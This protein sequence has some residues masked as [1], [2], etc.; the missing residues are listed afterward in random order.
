MVPKILD[1]TA[2]NQ[3]DV[4]SGCGINLDPVSICTSLY[5]QSVDGR[6]VLSAARHSN[7]NVPPSAL[8][9]MLDG[10]PLRADLTWPPHP[11]GSGDIWPP[12]SVCDAGE[13]PLRYPAAYALSDFLT[14]GRKPWASNSARIRPRH[15]PSPA[16]ALAAVY[17]AIVRP[18]TLRGL[19]QK[20]IVVI[21]NNL[22]SV[23]QQELLDE[24]ANAG[25]HARLLW[26]PVAA[27]LGLEV[28]RQKGR[29]GN[30]PFKS[31][32]SVGVLHLGLDEWE[33]TPMEYASY[34]GM[35]HLVPA[36][37][38]PDR[39]MTLSSWGHQVMHRVAESLAKSSQAPNVWLYVWRLLWT[40]PWQELVLKRL[41]G[42]ADRDA[43][44]ASGLGESFMHESEAL[45]KD[46][47]LQ[48]D[49]HRLFT[50]VGTRLPRWCGQAGVMGW[51][52]LVKGI[53]TKLGIKSIVVSGPLASIR[54]DDGVRLGEDLTSLL[55]GSHASPFAL[56]AYAPETLLGLGAGYCAM[57]YAN[58][59]IVYLDSLP[60]IS[61][62]VARAG[63]L[64]WDPLLDNGDKYV[65][66]GIVWRSHKNLEGF[67]IRP[68][69]TELT[70]AVDHE[71]YST[72][73]EVKAVIGANATTNIEP[74]AL[75]MA[76]EPAAGNAR[77]EVVP[78]KKGLF[79][80]KKIFIE[81]KTMADT[82][83]NPADWVAAQPRIHPGISPRLGSRSKWNSVDRTLDEL[84]DVLEGRKSGLGRLLEEAKSQLRSPEKGE[85][86]EHS[87]AVSSDGVPGSHSADTVKK[88][89]KV[90]SLLIDKLKS[91][92]IPPT[93]DKYIDALKVLGGLSSPVK[94]VQDWIKEFLVS[95]STHSAKM[96]EGE[97]SLIGGCVR[98]VDAISLFVR[99]VNGRLK[100]SL[101]GVNDWLKAL[102]E[103]LLYR[104]DALSKVD[105]LLCVELTYRILYVFQQQL[106][107]QNAAF[108]FRYSALAIVYLLRRRAWDDAY[109]DPKSKPAVSAKAAFKEAI[110]LINSR[111]MR[112]IGGV[113]NI[114]ATLQQMI[115]YIDR[116]GSGRILMA[117]D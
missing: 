76:I 36:R 41:S 100:E 103:V 4:L 55:L 65:P 106:A 93:S 66:G 72:V 80:N 9:P 112:A 71:E 70:I 33:F 73:R 58:G 30:V 11:R 111:K 99:C 104:Q 98:D 44:V 56:N 39:G 82:G 23:L 21:S 117:I 79:G 69:T 5:H 38:R 108:L 64:V 88:V 54:L 101:T 51:M 10:E 116:R 87:T 90:A 110:E 62:V 25:V 49:T 113:V 94:P 95:A 83:K 102:S 91:K 105:S 2:E 45:W 67:A 6:H 50:D 8:L 68:H 26:R 15:T 29:I 40:T 22:T 20:P 35:K 28:L 34:A 46:E 7:L 63:E 43:E 53:C 16:Q 77:V 60:R 19:V 24:L 59:R 114:P 89:N 85:Q 27:L 92:S 42:R 13:D 31:G 48:L 18:L 17:G 115:D 3:S 52:R 75:S 14:G 32:E 57:E 86:G 37:R 47:L 74:V 96:T 84:L 81:W 12:E 97:L 78:K 109:L 1:I 61:T 107:Q